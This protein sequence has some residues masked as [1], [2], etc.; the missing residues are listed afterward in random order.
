MKALCIHKGIIK[1]RNAAYL[2]ARKDAWNMWI[3]LDICLMVI[4]ILV[5]GRRCQI[6]RKVIGFSFLFNKLLLIPEVSHIRN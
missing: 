4:G 5:F 1:Y 2:L 3:S 6:F